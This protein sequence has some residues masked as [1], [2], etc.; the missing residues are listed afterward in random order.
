M[1]LSGAL[2]ALVAQAGWAGAGLEAKVKAAYI[3]NF[4]LF[5]EWPELGPG[6]TLRVCVMGQGA[7]VDALAPIVGRTAN[8][9]PIALYHP[10]DVGQASRCQLLYLAPSGAAGWQL[11]LESLADHSVLTVSDEGGFALAGGIIGFV[12]RDRRLQLEINLERARRAG[13]RISSKLL[14]VAFRVYQ[15]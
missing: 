7:V 11:L 10:T 6:A 5:V 15:P 12:E 3:Y 9:R 4:L 13:L 1:S 8:G 14:E 2:L